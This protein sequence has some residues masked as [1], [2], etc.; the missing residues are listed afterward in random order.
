MSDQPLI[1]L[2]HKVPL[3]CRDCGGP[4]FAPP[5]CPTCGGDTGFVNRRGTLDVCDDP[6]HRDRE[7]ASSLL[8]VI[9]QRDAA[10]ELLRQWLV[11]VDLSGVSA[12]DGAIPDCPSLNPV[13]ELLRKTRELTAK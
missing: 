3:P 12:E 4:L 5:T 1:C 6:W 8:D 10:Y 11:I 2:A 9:A 13:T 7:P